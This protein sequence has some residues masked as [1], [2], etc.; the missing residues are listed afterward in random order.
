AFDRLMTRVN[1]WL[2]DTVSEA[3]GI[4]SNVLV[5]RLSQ[6]IAEIGHGPFAVSAVSSLD[7]TGL[8]RLDTGVVR[9][10]EVRIQIAN[11]Q[12]SVP[13]KAGIRR[14]LEFGL[15]WSRGMVSVLRAFTSSS[16][17]SSALLIIDLPS[18]ALDADD[19]SRFVEY[20]RGGSIGPL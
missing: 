15:Y 3:F 9:S 13:W 12:I 11:G 16:E 4:R 2:A 20:C 10:N 6:K 7:R 8:F 14:L 17:E 18:D 1:D 5:D 19:D